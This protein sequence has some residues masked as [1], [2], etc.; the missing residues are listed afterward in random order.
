[1]SSVETRER[2]ELLDLVYMA[3]VHPERWPSVLDRVATLCEADGA[4]LVVDDLTARTPTFWAT[5][6]RHAADFERLYVARHRINPWLLAA[7]SRPTPSVARTET[8]VPLEALQASDFYVDC[9]EPVGWLHAM[10]ANL[11]GEGSAFAY[12]VIL[13]SPTA[14]PFADTQL[15]FMGWLA[16]HVA[17]AVRVQ[18]EIARTHQNADALLCLLDSL[19]EAVVLLGSRRELVFAN[20]AASTL[21]ER[22]ELTTEGPEGL[23]LE[24]ETPSRSGTLGL[25]ACGPTAH[26]PTGAF[27]VPRPTQGPP[28]VCQLVPLP[29]GQVVAHGRS[30]HELVLIRDPLVRPTLPEGV[31]TEALGITP[32]ELRVAAALLEGG[33]VRAVGARLGVSPNTVR[34]HLARLFVKTSTTRRAELIAQLLA[35]ST[36]ARP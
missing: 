1:M 4:L 31:L 14:G 17:R 32:A 21:L 7:R 5:T 27:T 10:G 24:H 35:F 25:L 9:L 12:A 2:E 36:P 15:L 3:A 26:H 8:L 20:R 33:S 34:S 22:G 16:G 11:Y 18:I 30:A 29:D 6:S 19:P 13:R 23:A 28:Y